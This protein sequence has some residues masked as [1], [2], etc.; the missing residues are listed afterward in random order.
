MRP[1]PDIISH[2]GEST[3]GVFLETVRIATGF[4]KDRRS[5]AADR[6]CQ[7][8][9]VGRL[10]GKRYNA[11]ATAAYRVV[12]ILG[13][14]RARIRSAGQKARALAVCWV[15]RHLAKAMLL[16]IEESKRGISTL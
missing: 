15:T 6:Y 13:L 14:D 3:G 1:L 4:A 7:E 2:V 10:C 11:F 9:A 8:T 16:T 12:R 5:P